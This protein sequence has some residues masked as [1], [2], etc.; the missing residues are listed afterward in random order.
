[1]SLLFAGIPGVQGSK[2][3]LAPMFPPDLGDHRIYELELDKYSG[4]EYATRTARDLLV[5]T[6]GYDELVFVG[7]SMGGIAAIELAKT[8]RHRL[9]AWKSLR[10]LMISAPFPGNADTLVGAGK[11]AGVLARM[12]GLPNGLLKLGNPIVRAMSG[13]PL[14]ARGVGSADQSVEAA[15]KHGSSIPF[16]R[17]ARQVSWITDTAPYEPG[18]LDGVFDAVGYFGADNGGAG[19]DG[20]VDWRKACR[21]YATVF[22]NATPFYD[23][24]AVIG[25][26]AA[27]PNYPVAYEMMLRRFVS[28]C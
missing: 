22:G 21:K 2:A 24:G 12:G 19:N 14:E 28:V 1:M 6:S 17:Y 8:V 27:I 9:P 4:R 11:A 16:A 15:H 25:P 23:L 5:N 20:V 13:S 18:D 3:Q 10:L 7:V 26:H